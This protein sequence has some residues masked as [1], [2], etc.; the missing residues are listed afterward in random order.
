MFLTVFYQMLA[1][2]ILIIVGFFL[3]RTDMLDDHMTS[4]LSV[5]ITKVFNPLL[6]LSSAMASLETLDQA[7][8]F[9]L[10]GIVCVIFLV[11]IILSFLVVPFME[12]RPGQKAMYQLMFIFGN[13]AF[14]GIPLVSGIYGPEY[15]AYVLPFIIAFNIYFYT[16]GMVLL[17]GRVDAKS[18]KAML[19][20]GSIGCIIAL[21]LI[22]FTP[23]IP[24]FMSVS[25]KYL[26][27]LCS[28][29]AMLIVGVSV[30]K[31]NLKAV[32]TTWKLYV[33]TLIRMVALPLLSI[34]VLRMLPFDQTI[35][36]VCLIEISMPI[37]NLTLAAS[38][39]KGLDT[40]DNSTGIIM[41]TLLSV[42]TLPIIVTL[43]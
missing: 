13:L 3:Y 18:L 23:P 38:M 1:L 20:P 40:T 8:W 2:A 43:L 27:D 34:P 9:M 37:A 7:S 35:I 21:L 14:M 16:F 32:F 15:T 19:N 28:P 25:V 4:K 17:N 31:S 22:I 33:F 42:I 41:T 11:L 6:M 5:L 29:L 12:R 30:A 24:S 10:F 36:G 26:G 39:E